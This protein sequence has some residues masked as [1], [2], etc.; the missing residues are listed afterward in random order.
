MIERLAIIVNTHSSCSDLWK[1]FFTEFE[2]FFPNQKIY[3]FS[4]ENNGLPTNVIPIIYSN[5]DSYRTQYLNC[6]MHVEEEYCL[7]LNEDYILYDYVSVDKIIRCID[8]LDNN[9]SFSFTRLT[10]GIEYG[11]PEISPNFYE[12]NNKNMWFFS[13]VATIWRTL[14]LKMVHEYCPESG[15]AF[16]VAGPQLELVANDVCRYLNLK[17]TFYYEGEVKRGQSH[18]DSNIFPY[19]AT[20]CIKGKWNLLEYEKELQPLLDTYN[21]DKNIRGIYEG[22]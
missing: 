2:K 20:A 16:K 22:I 1:I 8:F 17:G 15:M 5:E 9:K 12:M 19:I 13:Q 10:K 7:T 21:V 14:D 11:E 6:I 18:Y 4:D 3:V